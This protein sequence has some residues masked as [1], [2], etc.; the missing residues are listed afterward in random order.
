MC[1]PCLCPF[2]FSSQEVN[3]DQFLKN[4]AFYAV[5]LTQDS[6]LGNGNNYYLANAGD[7]MGW[8]IVQYDHNNAGEGG[9]CQGADCNDRLIYWSIQRPTCQDLQSNQ[10]AGPLLSD[11]ALHARY[12]DYVEMFLDT[13]LSNSSFIDELYNEI[14][15]IQADAAQDF[16]SLGGYFLAD[17]MSLDPSKW[18]PDTT[19]SLFAPKPW[20]P[21]LLARQAEVRIQL[22]AL[23]N[24]TF[25]RGPHLEVPVEKEEVIRGI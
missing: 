13:V 16:W 7:G 22:E 11:P 15:A 4:F 8:N 3:V 2:Y 17:E 21:F 5:T 6:P 20:L 18:K 25:P 10:I 14:Q 24:G 23:S 9:L 19:A 1:S 12:I